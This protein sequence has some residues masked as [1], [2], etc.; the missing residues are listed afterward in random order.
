MFLKKRTLSM[1]MLIDFPYFFICLEKKKKR[2]THTHFLLCF[3]DSG[4]SVVASALTLDGSHRRPSS[5]TLSENGTLH[6]H[7]C[8]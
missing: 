1:W 4:R 5:G 2:P 3:S 7:C 6:N 8:S